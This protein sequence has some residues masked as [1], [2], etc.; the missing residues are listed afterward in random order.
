MFRNAQTK[1]DGVRGYSEL[2]LHPQILKTNI[3]YYNLEIK[4]ICNC[5]VF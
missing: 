3:L 4:S 2:F 5:A 1:P